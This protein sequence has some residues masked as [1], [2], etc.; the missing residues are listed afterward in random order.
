MKPLRERNQV[1]VGAVTLVLI[2]LVTA[3]SY[4]SD[5][6]PLLGTGTTYQAYFAEAAGLVPDNEVQVAGVRVGQVTSVT[7]AGKKVLVKFKVDGTRVGSQSTASIGIK[8]LL[9]EKYLG[10]Q[11]KGPGAQNPDDPIPLDR[12]TT[13][14]QL[15]DAFQQLSQTVGDIDTQQLAESFNAVSDALKNTPQ[16]LKDTLNGLTA[17][18]KTVSS[19]DEQ[20]ANLLGNTSRL[21]QT[22]ADRDTQLRQVIDDGNLLLDELQQR[23]NAIS[24]LLTGTRQLAAQLA[25]LVADNRAQLRPTLDKL[26]EVTDILQ[27]NQ[28]NLGRSL[29][30][31]APFTRV[32]AN[33]TGNG[34]WFEGYICGLLPPVVQSGG[35]SINPNGCT[36]PISAPDQG[37]SGGN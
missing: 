6:I 15:Q 17:L 37:V 21:S 27:R 2:A 14:F 33:A 29:A 32:G 5:Q 31:L 36:P 13:P 11:P 8:T 34:R 24:A 9:G 12:T 23:Q 20:L 22:L 16:P 3:V 30:L 35:I 10:L 26:G 4:F 19:R 18:S 1:A 7:L 28:D 25:G